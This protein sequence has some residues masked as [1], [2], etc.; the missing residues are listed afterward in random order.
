MINSGI[1]DLRFEIVQVKARVAAISGTICQI[2]D[3]DLDDF[4][5]K[6]P[7]HELIRGSLRLQELIHL[8]RGFEHDQ[9]AAAVE[10]VYR[11]IC[12]QFECVINWNDPV[13]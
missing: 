11:N 7:C 12:G 4:G 6:V 5:R 8:T 10:H 9:M 3:A 13:G 2:R 1:V